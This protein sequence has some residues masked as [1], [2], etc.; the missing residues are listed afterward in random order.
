MIK[1]TVILCFLIIAIIYSATGIAEAC[2]IFTV[3]NGEDVLFGNNEDYSNPK[4]YY[5]V[6]PSGDETYG[7][8]YF[9]F[10][11]FW[12]QGGIN[13]KG[14]AF[15]INSLA[16]T[17]LNP[18]PELPFFNTYEGYSIL[19]NCASVE[20]AIEHVQKFNWGNAMWG[21]VQVA[22]A[23]GDAVIV[24]PGSDGELSF[25]RKQAGDGFLVSA[26]FNPALNTEEQE[27]LCWRYDQAVGMLEKIGNEVALS[28][29]YMG[30]VLDAVHVEGAYTNTL[31]STVYDLKNGD[32]SIY[33][34]H[35][36]DEVVELNVA[37]EI[38]QNKEAVFLADLFSQSIVN[39]ASAEQSRYVFLHRL[40]VELEL[41]GAVLALG[42]VFFLVRRWRKRKAITLSRSGML[43]AGG[44][45]AIIAGAIGVIVGIALLSGNMLGAR[46]I[47]IGNVLDAVTAGI[48]S[49]SLGLFAI[50]GGVCALRKKIFVIAIV[51]GGVCGLLSSWLIGLLSLIFIVIS[52]KEFREEANEL[53]TT[54]R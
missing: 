35:Q 24:G 45:L 38:S 19:R 36:F 16:E 50:T 54:G 1:K 11:N 44:V 15:D 39:R 18:H 40:V 53:N 32:I 52:K 33:Y 47:G 46:Y 37:D 20:E 12:P 30:A 5:W 27:G 6:E 8:V 21:Q 28:P 51:A 3:S 26:N 25:T 42:S 34:F 7:G 48:V 4:T 49:L 14:L 17:P 23:T 13:E 9:G 10:D 43:A 29:E 22:D 41:L 31:Y 2:T